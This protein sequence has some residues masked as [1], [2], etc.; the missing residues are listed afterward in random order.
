[1]TIEVPNLDDMEF[2]ERVETA[3]RRLPA[4]DD[5]W[6]DYNPSDPGITILELL[7][8]LSDTYTYQLDTVTDAH[9]R[10]YL[11]LMGER[12]RPPQ[13]ASIRLGMSIEDGAGP[14]RI[15]GGTKLRVIDRGDTEKV[16]EVDDDVVLTDA[17]IHRIVTVHP[18]GESDHTQANQK[19]GMHFPAFGPEAARSSALYLGFDADPFREADSLSLAV[20]FHDDD[21]P[22]PA[23]HAMDEPRF[24]PSVSL[25]WE[26]CTDYERVRHDDVWE[27][28]V[29]SRDGT[30]AFYR[31]GQITLDRPESWDPE[32]WGTAE[33]GVFGSEPGILWLRCRVVRDGHE[34]PPRLDTIALNVVEARHRSTIEEE[35][36]VRVDPP[37]DLA[38]LNAQVYAFE[39]SPVLDAEIAVDGTRW[40]DVQDFDASGPTDPHYVLDHAAGTVRF[41][42]GIRGRMPEP[43]ATVVA[44]RYAY[45]GGRAGNVPASST[46]RFLEPEIEIEGGLT[47]ADVTVTA[48]HGG[49]GGTDGES[50]EAAFRRT[51][52]DLR[53]PYRAITREDYRDVALHTPGLRVGR[54]AVIVDNRPDLDHEGVPVETKVVVVPVVPANQ[55]RPVPSEGFLEAVKR[56]LDTYRL[57]TDRVAVQGPDYV[58]LTV[59]LDVH[60]STP[61]PESRVR[62]AV[63]NAITSYI[64]PIYGYEGTGWPFGRTLYAEELTELLARIEFID[65]I[66]DIAIHAHGDARVDG[67]QNVVIGDTTLFAVEMIDTDVHAMIADRD[68]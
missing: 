30:F 67:D 39:H 59:D 38:T 27:R 26:Y 62:R 11:H 21:L 47:L 63:T 42:N 45:G 17:S 53:V 34:I 33:E 7:A 29:V 49:T 28:L 56:H 52:R 57:V 9:R 44:E 50:L 20:D 14:T 10:K 60:T 64:H 65:H 46:W 13:P 68:G 40:M 5:G 22:D 66:R 23:T 15:P 1:M 19:E 32:A 41:G 48:D 2:E 35:A 36:L 6:T 16:F 58:D 4:Y 54:A 24:F 55:P 25:I 51:K 18:D 61:L 43:A 12:A 8:Q 37:E 31:S 3:V